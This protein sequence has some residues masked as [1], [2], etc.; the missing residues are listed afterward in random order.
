MY[1]DIKHVID[2]DLPFNIVI[3]GRGIG[4]T[5]S[6]LK[7]QMENSIKAIYLRTLQ[8][9]IDIVAR[10]ESN[11]YKILNHDL[12]MEYKIGGKKIKTILDTD[13]NNVGYALALST[14]AS[15]RGVDFSDVDMIIW[16]EFISEANRERY[17]SDETTL[18]FNLYET[19]NRNREIQGRK[20]VQVIMLSNAVSISSS[21]LM[22]LG[23]V[24]TIENMI[25]TGQ[26]RY[27]DKNRGLYLEMPLDMEI[28]QKKAET[29][30]YRLAKNTDYADHALKNMFAYDSWYNIERRNIT[31]YIPYCAFENIYIYVHKKN[32]S[33]YACNIRADCPKYNRDTLALFKR[34]HYLALREANVSGNLIFDTMTT[35]VA[36]EKVL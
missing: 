36:L 25:K 31:E 9:E 6:T 12:K 19:V 3:G 8:S 21:L 23:L 17:L 28:S 20:P 1:Y 15:L 13:N 14:F 10:P 33:F 26:R 34:N 27:T 30:L 22:G 7:W 24:S 16:D 35:K 4:K 11:P 18:F 29:A 2:R 5:Y 32:S